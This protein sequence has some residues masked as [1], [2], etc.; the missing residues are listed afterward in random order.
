MFVPFSEG[1]CE[2]EDL[3]GLP[4]VEAGDDDLLSEEKA[5]RDLFGVHERWIF[6][7]DRIVLDGLKLSAFYRTQSLSELSPTMSTLSG[8]RGIIARW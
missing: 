6:R 5:E 3:D 8:Y 1:R 2:S 7:I 4:Y